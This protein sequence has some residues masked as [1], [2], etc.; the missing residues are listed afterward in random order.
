MKKL[1]LASA[2][3]IAAAGGYYYTTGLDT[4]SDPL[5]SLIPAEAPV[6]VVQTEAYDH[7]E[8]VSTVGTSQESL[9]DLLTDVELT[10]EQD[11]LVAYLDG[12]LQSAVDKA[13]FK[14]YL[15]A[16]DKVKPVFYTLGMIPVYK[17][18]IEDT[19]AF[20]NTI[21]QTEQE[22]KATHH[23]GQLGNV[24]YRR[25]QLS[26]QGSEDIGL[27]IAV[28]DNVA[29][30][31]LDVPLLKEANPLKLALGVEKP[32]HSFANSDILPA[33]QSKYGKQY[34]A[35]GYFDH[36]EI[37][38][39][40]TQPASNLLAQQ[41]DILQ[42]HS[43]E[44]FI[45]EI[46]Q[47]HCQSE[48]ATIANHWP[49]TVSFA[50]Y[51]VKNEQFSLD[52]QVVV[53]SHNSVILDALKSIRGFMPNMAAQD[54]IFEVGFGLDV[55][56]LAPAI[57]T[58][59]QDLQ[60]PTY[61]CAFLAETQQEMGSENPSAMLSMG[62]SMV[63]GMKGMHFTLN[64]IA[65]DTQNPYAPQFDKLDF[66]FT[67]SAENPIALVQTAQMFIPQ[68][69][70]LTIQPN[71]EPVDLSTLLESETG[72][73]TPLFARLNDKHLALYSGERSSADSQSVL[74]ASLEAKGLFQFGVN[75]P[76]LL[77]LVELISEMNG[78]E[79]PEDISAGLNSNAVTQVTFDVNDHGFIFGYEHHVKTQK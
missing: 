56:K 12:Y 13:T 26:D 2:V 63:N 67:L 60:Q 51:Q 23:V 70:Q 24:A 43:P 3:A 36:Q 50:R 14:A 15:G 19:T 65:L 10:P 58:I 45:E 49:R 73:S 1:L 48:L 61:Q 6:V 16:P 46:R 62:S 68:L 25:Y 32:Q 79:I 38:K 69:S 20:W 8:Y 41:I 52:G 66:L 34:T 76:R 9:Y 44:S 75:A 30:F 72:V 17:I 27:V 4:S 74:T 28:E 71:A 39:G 77:E 47:P 35:Y 54:S 33:L 40:L 64:D 53:E 11:F 29:T 31:T 5:L 21:D 59:W 37:I 55:A 18:E 7:F 78:E 57:N 42:Q 22:T